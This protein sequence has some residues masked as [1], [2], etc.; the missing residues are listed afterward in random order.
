MSIGAH[1]ER[2]S[3]A[4]TEMY[5]C[6]VIVTV[7]ILIGRYVRVI[8]MPVGRS[9]RVRSADSKIIHIYVRVIIV[10]NNTH[11]KVYKYKSDNDSNAK[12]KV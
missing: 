5:I 10:N 12:R 9:M 6:D 7:V 1:C 2:D 8:V 4:G 3:N 11:R